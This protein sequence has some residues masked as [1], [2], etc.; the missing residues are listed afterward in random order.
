MVT[1][2]SREPEL[3]RRRESELV[4]WTKAFIARSR[5][6]NCRGEGVCCLLSYVKWP[7]RA[8]S[9]KANSLEW[10]QHLWLLQSRGPAG[11]W[12]RQ[13][14]HVWEGDLAVLALPPSLPGTCDW[15][16][17]RPVYISLAACPLCFSFSTSQHFCIPYL[18]YKLLFPQSHVFQNSCLSHLK[19]NPLEYL[20]TDC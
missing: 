3:M 10:E 6:I 8:H 9:R 20:L 11:S 16:S 12:S 13:Q 7:G 18:L 5:H 4:W 17:A 14:G 19:S 15:L 1:N 2:S